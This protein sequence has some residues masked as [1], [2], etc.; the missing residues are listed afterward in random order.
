MSHASLERMCILSE[1]QF[2]TLEIP[3]FV[4]TKIIAFSRFRRH[5]TNLEIKKYGDRK[6]GTKRD[7]GGEETQRDGNPEQIDELGS[8]P[9]LACVMLR[10]RECVRVYV[11]HRCFNEYNTSD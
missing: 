2:G 9:R 1:L 7:K 11:A 5:L 6:N 8:E 10:M 4:C 3:S